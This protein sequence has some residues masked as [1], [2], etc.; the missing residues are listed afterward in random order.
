MATCSCRPRSASTRRHANVRPPT[1]PGVCSAIH[2]GHIDAALALCDT[3]FPGVLNARPTPDTPAR[4]RSFPPHPVSLNPFHLWLNLHMQQFVEL[5]RTLYAEYEAQPQGAGEDNATLQA[6]LAEIQ[7]LNA[8]VRT[9]P[10]EESDVYVA[11][12]DAM[13]A[14][15]AYTTASDTPS[16]A[17]LDPARRTALAAQINSAMLAHAGLPPDSVLSYITRHTACVLDALHD[18]N[19]QVPR[20]HPIVALTDTEA[21]NEVWDDAA[22]TPSPQRTNGED[23]VLRTP[24]MDGEE[25]SVTLPPWGA[26]GVVDL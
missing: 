8:R 24:R 11:Q 26:L 14:L 9:L 21:R 18:E 20:T 6:A 25:D 12:I 23:A 22:S 10:Q 2:D 1:H 7:L 4:Q 15:L 17:I 19:V 13:V 3:H 16:P 5:V